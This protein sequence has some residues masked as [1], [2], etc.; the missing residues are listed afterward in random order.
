MRWQ[1]LTSLNQVTLLQRLDARTK[2]ALAAI[3]C[4]T[5]LL[6]DTPI[7]LYGLWLV[8]LALHLAAKTSWEKWLLLMVLMLAGI[9]GSVTSQALFY[10]KE[11]RTALLCLVASDTGRLLFRE[12]IYLYKEGLVYGAL[13]A[14]R[15]SIML[16]AGLLLCW[17]TDTREL[18]KSLLYWRLP[19]PLAF[20]TISSLRF[21][22]DIA[23]E[24]AAVMTAQRLRGF[25]PLRSLRPLRLAQT[26]YQTLF[27]VL[28]RTLRRAAILSLSVEAR[29]FGSV[30][31][32][33]AVMPSWPGRYLVILAW[34]FILCLFGA[35]LTYWLQFGGIWYNPLLRLVYD[36]TKV[37]L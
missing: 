10:A 11:P 8:L 28:A 30:A 25:R 4:L 22:P 9:W 2:L 34:V 24:T 26:F 29:G 3:I 15:S 1:V 31:S 23:V 19:Y 35:K 32:R 14:L 27:P 13:Q 5:A 7:T 36:F 18:L 12:G 6:V 33:V 21:L 20:M 37:W 16:T 17:N